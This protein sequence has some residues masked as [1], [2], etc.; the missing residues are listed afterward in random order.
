MLVHYKRW[1]NATMLGFASGIPGHELTRVRPTTFKT[2]NHTFNHILVVDT[3]FKAHLTGTE[4]P[5]RA[6]NTDETPILSEIQNR[7]AGID[8]WYVDLVDNMD[9]DDFDE[10]VDFEFV[11][12]GQGSMTRSDILLHLVN[13]TTYHHGYV[14]DMMYQIPCEPPAIDLTVFLR[15]AWT[16]GGN[17]NKQQRS[18]DHG[19]A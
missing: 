17:R 18:H 7:T 11:G 4:H 15:D 8:D 13:H 6:R 1:M 10:A 2:I 5:Y 9:A 12:G 16:G 3:I 19:S 14:S